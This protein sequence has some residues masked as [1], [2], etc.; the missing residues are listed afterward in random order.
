MSIPT[1]PIDH[2][3]SLLLDEPPLV[4]QRPLVRALGG[5]DLACFLQQ[6]H[7]R[8]RVGQPH[9]G[10]LWAVATNAE[11]CDDVALTPRQLERVLGRLTSLGVLV[12]VQPAHYDRT[13]WRRVDHDRLEV[14][15]AEAAEVVMHD[16]QT[17]VM[18][19]PQTGVN[20]DPQ[21]GVMYLSPREIEENPNTP[22][23][24]TSPSALRP[25]DR[26]GG[27]DQFWSAYPRKVG[28]N[29]KGGA[30]G[31][32]K[33]A[34]THATVEQVLA[35][36]DAWLDHWRQR[37]EPEFIPYPATW[38]N[39]HRWSDAPPPVARGRRATNLEPMN[40]PPG[41]SAKDVLDALVARE[42]RQQDLPALNA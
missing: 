9:D 26:D 38:L 41:V 7:Y 4:I 31:A 5:H 32:W 27:F 25:D 18:D 12:S 35:G 36:L 37:G 19:D 3:P 42:R 30:S 20:E 29:G 24:R 6:V 10:H 11:W 40:L 21:T 16:H 39:Q 2:Q 8:A 28:K 22:P 17:V 13:A 15:L 14:L 33:R 1:T 34:M 23:S